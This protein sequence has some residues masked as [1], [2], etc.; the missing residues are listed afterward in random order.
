MVSGIGRVDGAAGDVAGVI[1]GGVQGFQNLLLLIAMAMLGAGLALKF[2][3]AGSHRTKDAA[4]QLID[5]AL[6]LGGLTAPGLYLVAF[7]A[8]VAT[9]ALPG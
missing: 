1:S 6:I 8:Q 9:T 4:G 3:P 5:N 7:A 2:L